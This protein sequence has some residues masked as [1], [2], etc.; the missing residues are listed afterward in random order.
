MKK[1]IESLLKSIELEEKEERRR[2]HLEDGSSIKALKT[3]GLAIHP[4]RILR[5]SFGYQDYPEITFS[6]PFPTDASGF[7]DGCAIE[8]F[9]SSEE[10]IKGMLLY[11]DGKKG[12]FRLFSPDFPDWIEEDGV[13]IKIAPDVRTTKRMKEAIEAIPSH[14]RLSDL[15]QRIHSLNEISVNKSVSF[16]ALEWENKQLNESQQKAISAIVLGSDALRLVH[17]PP[18]T[19]KT[20]TLVEAVYQ[21][22]KGHKRV[23][24]SAPSNAAVDHFTKQLNWRHP[25]IELLRI[26]NNSKISEA[27]LPFTPEGKLK[28]SKEEK[29]MKRLKI[30]AEELRK[31]AHQYKRHFGKEE[32]DQRNL[33]LKEVKQFRKQIR[34]IQEYNEEKLFEKAQVILGTP[35]AISD[36]FKSKDTTFDVLIIDEAGQ[37]LEPLAWSIFPISERIVLAGDHFQLPPTLLSQE[38]IQLGFNKSILEVCTES[39]RELNLLNIQYRMKE[40]IA[41]FS[42]RYFYQGKIQTAIPLQSAEQHIFFYDTA[43]ADCEEE[44]GEHGMS[45]VNKGEAMTIYKLI[46]YFHFSPE[47]TVLISPYSEQVTYL[48]ELLPEFNVSTIDSYQGQEAENVIISLVRSNSDSVIGFLKDYRRMNVAMTR[49][50]NNLVVIGDSATLGSDNFYAQFLDYVESIQAYH[51]VWELET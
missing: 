33:I 21:L 44:S 15:F 13:G 32:R 23:L 24:I 34:A 22:C 14:K 17:G 35:M 6:S 9:C 31:I 36:E 20:T 49:A 2:Y 39:V 18:G 5:K 1:V 27:I 37:C 41:E 46:A 12:E 43:G 48:R 10:S 11:F 29:E 3:N 28:N 30:Q 50:K 16:P 42:N 8:L 47:N 51:S 26:G 45:L 4:I 40:P 19:G 25:K 7:R 38:A